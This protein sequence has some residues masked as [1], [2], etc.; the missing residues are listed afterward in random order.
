M[1]TKV[2]KVGRSKGITLDAALLEA[3][4]LKIGDKL[5]AKFE[6]D[7]TILLTP[8][9]SKPSRKKVSKVIKSTMKDYAQTMKKLA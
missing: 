2:I 3:L 9:R 4:H 5:T 1:I 6:P 7:G 8:V